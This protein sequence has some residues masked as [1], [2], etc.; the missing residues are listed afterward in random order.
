MR[1]RALAFLL[2]LL[3]APPVG[4]HPGRL[5]AEGCH[6]VRKDFVYQSGTV[7][8]KG[9]F[10]CHRTVIGR[11]FR[12]D[13][14]EVLMEDRRDTERDDDTEGGDAHDQAP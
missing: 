10:H 13:G 2:M 6:H 4:A 12:L 11:P 7:A 1:C 14:T 3:V 8:K 9:D 5:D